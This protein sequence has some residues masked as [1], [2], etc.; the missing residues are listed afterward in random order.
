MERVRITLTPFHFIL[1]FINDMSRTKYKKDNFQSR[2][3]MHR[4]FSLI[5][6]QEKKNHS[7]VHFFYR[8]SVATATR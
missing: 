6:F 2:E 4:Y 8:D 3:A 1:I 5:T 7:P